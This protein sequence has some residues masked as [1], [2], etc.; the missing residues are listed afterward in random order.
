MNRL[1]LHPG[2]FVL[3]VGVGE[4]G[5]GYTTG[6]C[7]VMFRFKSPVEV[8]VEVEG[9][10]HVPFQFGVQESSRVIFSRSTSRSRFQFQIPKSAYRKVN[11]KIFR[12]QFTVSL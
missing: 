10:F 8:E 5:Q 4:E 6:G 7:G 1:R 3:T 12:S 2:I 9:Q 11:P